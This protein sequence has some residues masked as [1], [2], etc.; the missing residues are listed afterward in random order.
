VSGEAAQGN[1]TAR[2][3]AERCAGH[4]GRVKRV[5]AQGRACSAWKRH[6]KGA[7]SLTGYTGRGPTARQ[8]V[9]AIWV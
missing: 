4:P 2:A 5:G 1:G 3:G 8:G 9:G 6:S 7:P